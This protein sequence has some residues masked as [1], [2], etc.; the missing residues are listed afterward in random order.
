MMV[1]QEENID[2]RAG[3]A[4][5]RGDHPTLLKALDEGANVNSIF[6]GISMLGWAFIR[7]APAPI[8]KALLQKGADPNL[9]GGHF[10]QHLAFCGSLSDLRPLLAKY[11]F[12]EHPQ[13]KKKVFD[14]MFENSARSTMGNKKSFEISALFLKAGA[15]WKTKQNTSTVIHGLLP[16]LTGVFSRPKSAPK[17]V[18]IE[19]WIELLMGYG[20]DVNFHSS[21][22]KIQTPPLI[23]CPGAPVSLLLKLGAD[24]TLPSYNQDPIIHRAIK[25]GNYNM[26]RELLEAGESALR[27][28]KDGCTALSLIPPNVMQHEGWLA[29]RALAEKN[30]LQNLPDATHLTKTLR[31]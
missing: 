20:F 11:P 26:A 13:E 19:K 21:E 4:V 16:R 30:Q 7:K 17:L 1:G 24:P 27:L 2:I 18:P 14:Y 31:I 28:N 9:P 10:W 12:K 15:T 6:H 22:G 29:V 8:R 5:L 23:H 25:S 3:N